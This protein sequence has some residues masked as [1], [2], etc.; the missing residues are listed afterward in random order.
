METQ[1]QVEVWGI[2]VSIAGRDKNLF[3]LERAQKVWGAHVASYSIG[4]KGFFSPG[5]ETADFE[6]DKSS[7]L[8]ISC[9][10]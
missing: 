4:T 8:H 3:L 7:F 10:R 1:L 6:A 9:R 2:V 5:V